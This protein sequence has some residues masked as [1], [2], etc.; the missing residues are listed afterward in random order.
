[1]SLQFSAHGQ[2]GAVTDFTAALRRRL[3]EAASRAAAKRQSASEEPK[4]E[5]I[6]EVAD[7]QS[8]Q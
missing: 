6:G 1:M 8:G 3:E 4:G 5:R 7:D 2:Q